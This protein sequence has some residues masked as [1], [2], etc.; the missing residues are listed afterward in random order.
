[1][2]KSIIYIADDGKEFKDESECYFYCWR[3]KAKKVQ[4]KLK[5]Y[6]NCF[7]PM[8]IEKKPD[9]GEIA[10]I[11]ADTDEAVDFINKWFEE[12]GYCAHID[13]TGFWYCDDGGNWLDL[14]KTTEHFVQTLRA[15]QQD[16]MLDS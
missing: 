10:Y 14:E 11:R 9:S 5:I 6:D 1:M 2:T 7:T 3:L 16:K 8:D 15:M 13:D 4:G 12:E